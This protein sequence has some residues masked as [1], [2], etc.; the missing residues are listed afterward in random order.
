MV[1]VNGTN[2]ERD[3]PDTS[4]RQRSRSGRAD[5]RSAETHSIG[6]VTSVRCA[7][8][9]AC[10]LHGRCVCARITAVGRAGLTDPR[11]TR[12]PRRTRVAG[13]ASECR[14]GVWRGWR[15]ARGRRLVGARQ[16]PTRKD[17]DGAT[18]G[19]GHCSMISTSGGNGQEATAEEPRKSSVRRPLGPQALTDPAPAPLGPQASCLRLPGTAQDAPLGPQASCLRLRDPGTAGTDTASCPR[20]STRSP[21]LGATSSE[22]PDPPRDVDRHSHRDGRSES[23]LLEHGVVRPGLQCRAGLAVVLPSRGGRRGRPLVGRR[24]DPVA[25]SMVLWPLDARRS[26]GHAGGRAHLAPSQRS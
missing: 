22:W 14:A 10:A 18:K 7:N 21:W 4:Q 24:K 19:T 2:L 16:K 13:A 23:L 12:E 3:V 17:C 26:R 6:L 11:D 1:D 8:F 15:V 9:Q 5:P 20:L 25:R